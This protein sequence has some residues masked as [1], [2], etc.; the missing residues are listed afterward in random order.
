MIIPSLGCNILIMLNI[1]TISFIEVHNP[2]RILTIIVMIHSSIGLLLGA[3][4]KK[5]ICLFTAENVDRC[6]G[7]ESRS[8]SR[9]IL[10]HVFGEDCWFL[11]Y[12]FWR[13]RAIGCCFKDERSLHTDLL[14]QYYVYMLSLV[15]FMRKTVF[16]C[17][18]S[19][20]LM[21]GEGR[22]CTGRSRCLL[23]RCL[24][25]YYLKREQEKEKRR[26]RDI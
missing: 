6:L 10:R 20:I 24:R 3:S 8:Q 9:N 1:E 13:K 12:Q 14:F 4:L 22:M 23:F 15:G 19:Q 5:K 21:F 26:T 25:C 18:T 11:D 17:R 7:V 2:I 16:C